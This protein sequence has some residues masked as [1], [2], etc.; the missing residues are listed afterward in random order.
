MSNV[1]FR[2][3]AAEKLMAQALPATSVKPRN[4]AITAYLTAS[5]RQCLC[6]CSV[7]VFSL[8]LLLQ[9]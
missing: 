6:M 2:L 9:S 7:K 4:K 5:A 8:F 3:T 1:L